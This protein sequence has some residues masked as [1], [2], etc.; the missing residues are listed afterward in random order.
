[1]TTVHICNPAEEEPFRSFV[2]G[3]TTVVCLPE[4][5]ECQLYVDTDAPGQLR[6]E[7]DGE[8]LSSQPVDSS[9]RCFALNEVLSLNQPSHPAA[10]LI[11]SLAN[12]LAGRPRR[13]TEFSVI[14]T[15]NDGNP[16]V[17]ATYNFKLLNPSEF[18]E[19]FTAHLENR[20]SSCSCA[21]LASDRQ[22]S[23]ECDEPCCWNC[24]ELLPGSPCKHC[25]AEQE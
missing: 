13:V 5:A 23:V 22:L 8:N 12:K 18:E 24:N 21:A 15:R 3:T 25:G 14:V 1:M 19:A 9:S 11:L 17:A 2:D 6:I 10:S 7:S 20:R 4:G 16:A